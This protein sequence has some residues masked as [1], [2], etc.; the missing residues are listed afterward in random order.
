MAQ[1]Q[2]TAGKCF[3]EYGWLYTLN[4]N[5]FLRKYT[6][7]KRTAIIYKERQALSANMNTC[8]YCILTL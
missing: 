3:H 7:M 5:L 1:L 4:L 2:K 8:W 6:L